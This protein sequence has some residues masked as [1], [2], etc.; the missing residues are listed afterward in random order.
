MVSY[1]CDQCGGVFETDWSEEEAQAE[2]KKLFPKE[3]AQGMTM[4]RICDDCF[5]EIKEL[6]LET[7]S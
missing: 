1:T 4:A 3:H 7:E 2:S 6:P 5:Q